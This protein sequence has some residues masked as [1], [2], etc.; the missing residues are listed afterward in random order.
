MD[1]DERELLA[2]SLGHATAHHTATSLDA[3]LD[4][5]GWRDALVADPRTAVST[6]FELQGAAG[7]TSSA[8]DDVLVTALG[9]T[10]SPAVAAV[11]PPLGR[12]DPPGA[13]VGTRVTVAGLGMSGLAGRDQALVVTAAP[14]SGGGPDRDGGAALLAPVGDLRLRA[15]HGLDPALG[16]VEVAGVVAPA[17]GTERVVLPPDA[18][19]AA[20]AAGQRALAHELVGAAR[21]M[22]DLARGHA[23]ERVQFGRPIA[24]FQAVRHRLAES[25]VAIDGADATLAAAWDDGSPLAAALAKAVAGR[26]ARTVAR[27]AQQVLAGIGF[28]TE[29]PLHRYVRRVVVLD[30]LLGDTRSLTRRLGAELLEQRALPSMLPL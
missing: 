2:K 12:C 3:A 1:D 28:T 16:V 18:W 6:L 8:L 30:H 26:G 21:A 20:V 29:H 10:P 22:L 4:D 5:L 19:P 14:G 25:R 24:G 9:L 11:L 27:H 15:V 13:T 7:S 17:T 23:L